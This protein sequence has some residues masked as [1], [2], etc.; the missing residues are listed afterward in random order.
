MNDSAIFDTFVQNILGVSTPRARNAI[1]AFVSTFNDLL[2]TTDEEI[3]A[4]VATTHSANS[5]RAANAKILIP[6][7]VAVS[8]QA[9]FFN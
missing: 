7:N 3:D 1:T 4:F 8:L 6:S 5:A 9:L 2:S